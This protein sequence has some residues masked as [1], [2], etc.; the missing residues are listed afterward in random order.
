MDMMQKAGY[1]R[2]CGWSA[3]DNSGVPWEMLEM[4]I[5]GATL[6]I[7]YADLVEVLS[8]GMAA[9]VERIGRNW[10]DYIGGLAGLAQISKSGKAIN[11]ELI[12]GDRFTVSLESLRAVIDKQ[13]RYAAVAE[14][15]SKIRESFVKNRLISEFSGLEGRTYNMPEMENGVT[16]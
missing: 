7:R 13:E 8:G 5:H 3:I 16:A 10:M 12:C 1:I 2:R 11:I 9:R 15:P 4:R 6:A 14:V